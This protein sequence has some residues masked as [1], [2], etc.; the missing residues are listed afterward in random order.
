MKKLFLFTLFELIIILNIFSTQK[1]V[2]NKPIHFKTSHIISTLNIEKYKKQ[3]TTWQDHTLKKAG[4]ITAVTFGSIMT[5]GGGALTWMTVFMATPDPRSLNTFGGILYAVPL[6][7]HSL[8]FGASIL[9]YLGIYK[10]SVLSKGL[11]S[12]W[13]WFADLITVKRDLAI[14]TLATSVVPL[15]GVI[16]NLAIIGYYYKES[17]DIS[18]ILSN[19]FIPIFFCSIFAVTHLA[20]GGGLLGNWCYKMNKMG[21]WAIHHLLPDISLTHD[22]KKD[23]T[24][25]YGVSVGMRVRI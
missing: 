12:D 20:V 13:S 6:A 4:A 19:F 1:N 18:T 3:R 10:L 25:G 7:A 23:I 8:F 11:Y 16:A 5:L 21:S 15:S 24:E 17:K 2:Y 22:D 9:L 14:V